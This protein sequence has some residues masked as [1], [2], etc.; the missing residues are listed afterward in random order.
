MSLD[1]PWVVVLLTIIA[2]IALRALILMI[3]SG[4]DMGRIWL[5][6]R[7]ASRTLRN[8]D[9][10]N[11]VRPLLEPVEQKPPTPPKPSGAPLRLL[12]LLQR[13][14][15]FIDFV[16]EDAASCDDAQIAAAVREM[17]PKWQA[18]IKQHVV[19]EPVRSEA[20]GSTIE[21]PP[22]FDPSAIL[23][24]GNVTGQPPFRGSLKHPGWR[25]KELKLPPLPQGQDE[26]IVMPAEVELP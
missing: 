21:V 6:F 4:G 10:A 16:L 24:T 3:L 15:R 20:E 1:N 19:L 17:Q 8:P 14:G 22:G 13:D 11:K 25:A 18:T 5:M 23:L 2:L 9:F 26:F 12:S 7:A